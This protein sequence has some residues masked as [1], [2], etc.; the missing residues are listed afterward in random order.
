MW[1]VISSFFRSL[2]YLHH[3][4]AQKIGVIRTSKVLVNLYQSAQ[5]CNPED[6]HLQPSAM[7]A[8]NPNKLWK[9]R[10][11]W[12]WWFW[13]WWLGAGTVWSGWWKS[14]FRRSLLS[15]FSI[16]NC[17]ATQTNQWTKKLIKGGVKQRQKAL[18]LPRLDYTCVRNA[19][20]EMVNGAV[21]YNGGMAYANGTS[22]WKKALTFQ[23]RCCFC[24]WQIIRQRSCMEG[25]WL[26]GF[27]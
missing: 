17:W 5:H 18:S 14:A 21:N 26:V 1:I 9:L 6:S 25:L 13:W 15:S 3:Q 7:R 10:L 2:Y 23:S 4:G 24:W 19:L 22:S 12:Q 20:L 11:S 27:L 8:S 16:L